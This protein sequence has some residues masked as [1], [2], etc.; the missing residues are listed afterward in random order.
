METHQIL[1]LLIT[2]LQLKPTN[3]SQFQVQW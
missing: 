3:T 1:Q 2:T